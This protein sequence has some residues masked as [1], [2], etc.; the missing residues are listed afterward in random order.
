MKEFQKQRH[1][2]KTEKYRCTKAESFTSSIEQIFNNKETLHTNSLIKDERI[3]PEETAIVNKPIPGCLSR[4]G[5][6]AA[7]SKQ[8]ALNDL[9]MNSFPIVDSACVRT[10]DDITLI[11]NTNWLTTSGQNNH[12]AISQW[13]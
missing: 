1:I 5:N 12:R 13:W 8:I 10:W 4:V 2:Y 7:E 9:K 6:I 11:V 3:E